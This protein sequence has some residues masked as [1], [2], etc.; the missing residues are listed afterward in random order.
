M[1]QKK[2]AGIT[3][4]RTVSSTGEILKMGLEYAVGE[5]LSLPLRI[6]LH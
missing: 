1:I 3:A 2:K 6:R 4:A 5:H